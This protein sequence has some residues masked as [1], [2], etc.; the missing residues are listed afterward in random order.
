[1]LETE[2]AGLAAGE[3]AGYEIEGW[4]RNLSPRDSRTLPKF[5]GGGLQ[6][7]SPHHRWVRRPGVARR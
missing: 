1:M 2:P 6:S 3:L 5:P 7:P 4:R